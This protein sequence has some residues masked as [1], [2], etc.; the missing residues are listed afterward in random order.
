MA[1]YAGK[2]L[3][4]DLSNRRVTTQATSDYSDTYLGGRGMATRIYWD[5]CRPEAAATDPDVPLIIA[6][7]PLA[8]VPAVGGSR[9]GMFSKTALQSPPRFCHGNLGGTFGAELKYAGYDAIVI[10][11][12]AE[13]PVVL[14]I[15]DDHVTLRP[16]GKLNGLKTVKAMES[17]KREGMRKSQVL[18]VGPAGERGIPYATVF[19]DGDASC[20][21]GIGASMGSKNLKAI[22]VRGS[23]RVVETN[24]PEELRRIA[25]E[26]RSFGRG[27]VKVWGL[28]FMAS[29][30]KVKKLPCAGC[31]A[32]CLRVTYK[33]DN[34]VTGKYMCQSRV[35]YLPYA[36]DFYGT[37]NDVPFLVNRLCDEFGIDTWALQEIVDW[38]DRCRREKLLSDKDA[39]FAL[40]KIGSLEFIEELLESI[41]MRRDLGALLSIGLESTAAALGPDFAAQLRKED[42]YDPRYCTVNA[43]LF[44]FD[45]REPIEQLHEAGLV[46][47]QWSSWD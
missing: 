28:D 36:L 14:S 27:N 18:C 37:E 10:T 17:L 41:T 39:G 45:T 9:W 4:V 21:G 31:M 35:F 25:R 1:S 7:G 47:S 6:L 29:G 42:P 12:K 24:N 23:R 46:L 11:G 32:S 8:G 44:P 26:I 16:G 19:A 43:L 30:P 13:S 33:A 15:E 40:S 38:L 2:V 3:R 5:E 34:G 22:V 20:S